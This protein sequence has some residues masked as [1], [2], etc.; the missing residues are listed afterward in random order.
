MSELATKFK[1]PG[2]IVFTNSDL[3]EKAHKKA[4][5]ACTFPKLIFT[6]PGDY[7]SEFYAAIGDRVR[8]KK[9]SKGKIGN[10]SRMD[11]DLGQDITVQWDD[12]SEEKGVWCGKKDTYQLVYAE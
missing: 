11:E 12:G 5:I 4:V 9:G 8:M 10:I 3:V 7:A 1:E 6:P 2:N